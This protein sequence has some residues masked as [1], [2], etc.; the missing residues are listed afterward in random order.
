MEYEVAGS[1]ARGQGHVAL[2]VEAAVPVA[3]LVDGV[4]T[5][6]RHKHPVVAGV[7]HVAVRVRS[8]LAVGHVVLH[9]EG[10]S[11]SSAV[12]LWGMCAVL[13]TCQR[14]GRTLTAVKDRIWPEV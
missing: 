12:L 7:E 2:V 14:Q 6:V 3:V 5:K 13:G 4:V 11:S 9:G 8:V 1:L 10:S